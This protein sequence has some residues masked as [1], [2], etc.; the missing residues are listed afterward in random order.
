MQRCR[1]IA[2]SDKLLTPIF[3]GFDALWRALETI[4]VPT[5]IKT[6]TCGARF[7][8]PI[9]TSIGSMREYPGENQF[10]FIVLDRSSR[11]HGDLPP[12][13]NATLAY[14]GRQE[15]HRGL[16]SFVLRGDVL[17]ARPQYLHRRVVALQTGVELT[18]VFCGLY[19]DGSLRLYRSRDRRRNGKRHPNREPSGALQDLRA[20]KYS[21]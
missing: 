21:S 18:H 6:G 5:K 15:L 10:Q 8:H 3:A 7:Y 13:A 14:L 4:R 11:R 19:I 16:V 12:N 9:N 20:V 1:K 17:E 2:V